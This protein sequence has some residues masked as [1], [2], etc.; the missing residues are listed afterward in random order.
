MF[1]TRISFNA[2]LYLDSALNIVAIYLLTILLIFLLI[3]FIIKQ[4]NCSSENDKKVRYPSNIVQIEIFK[5][6]KCK[7]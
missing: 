3:Y 4:D 1:R 2:D 5:N 6:E 7:I